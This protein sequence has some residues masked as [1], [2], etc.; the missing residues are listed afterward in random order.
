[1][2]C[3]DFRESWEPDLGKLGSARGTMDNFFPEVSELAAGRAG[4]GSLPAGDLASGK[5]S[6]APPAP[7][8]HPLPRALSPR[9]RNFRGVAR[10]QAPGW[11]VSRLSK[12]GKD[13]I[14]SRALIWLRDAAKVSVLAQRRLAYRLSR[15]APGEVSQ[16]TKG[17]DGRAARPA[18]G[19]RETP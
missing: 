14:L 6:D 18:A 15:G 9:G 2:G 3:I 5:G 11:G 17:P 12:P 7:R 8:A 16:R 13:F 1:M 10:N 19:V 4:A